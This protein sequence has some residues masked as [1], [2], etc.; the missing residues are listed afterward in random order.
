MFATFRISRGSGLLNLYA[1]INEYDYLAFKNERKILL[2]LSF[3]VVAL[4]FSAKSKEDGQNNYSYK[5]GVEFFDAEKYDDA[6]TWFENEVASTLQNWYAYYYLSRIYNNY[7]EYGKALTAIN[8]S[9]KYFL[10]KISIGAPMLILIA[11]LSIHR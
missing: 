8:T 1:E 3:C 10:K 9:I 7:N 2:L 6:K 11:F 4:I 5:R